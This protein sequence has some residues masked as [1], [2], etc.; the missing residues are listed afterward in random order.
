MSL[1][2]K[3]LDPAGI[4]IFTD[5]TVEIGEPF[6]RPGTRMNPFPVNLMFSGG[7]L[8]DYICWTPAVQW[9]AE[10]CPYVHGRVFAPA[11]F[12]ELAQHWFVGYP[13]WKVFLIDDYASKCGRDVGT[14][15][16]DAMGRAQLVNAL[17]AHLL[18]LGFGYFPNRSPVPPEYNYYPDLT[19][20][21]EEGLPS[22]LS[23]LKDKYV[24]FTP[25]GTSPV[26]TVPGHYWNP[27]IDYVRSQGLTPV[28]LGKSVLSSTHRST[29]PADMDVL[30]CID[31]RDRTSLLEVA[32]IMKY[33]YATLGLDNGLLHL[34]ACTGGRFIFTYNVVR[35]DHRKPRMRHNGRM[36]EL[37]LSKEELPCAGCQSEMSILLT[38]D[39][40]RCLYADQDRKEA[41]SAGQPYIAPKCI[42]M[43]FGDW[44][45]KKDAPRW[46]A[47]LKELTVL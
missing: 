9:I 43:L 6:F 5:R 14:I 29:F 15:G 13:N 40:K 20:L 25:G 12:F 41:E 38:H 36:I 44:L 35:P 17:G 24:V 19:D 47:A 23:L 4:K 2:T 22:S 21:T 10:N 32:V 1:V 33:A 3:S 27:V 26:R 16:P 34:A 37:F 30:N 28:L 18:D 31:L 42:D 46:I 7:G 11:F 8:G 45:G 39:F